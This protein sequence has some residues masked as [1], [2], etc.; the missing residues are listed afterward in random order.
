MALPPN[1]KDRAKLF[2]DED[3]A[4]EW[5]E[6]ERWPEGPVCP[7]CGVVDRA[8]KLTPKE[9]SSRPVRKGVWKCR[10]CRK[11]FTVTIGTIFAETHIPLNKW[12]YAIH[13]MCSSKK[14]ISANQLSRDLEITYKSA[15][16][17]AHRI[18]KAMEK[19]PMQE[20]LTG[21]I[22]A[23]ETFVGGKRRGM[24]G[25]PTAKGTKTIVFTLVQRD[26]EARSYVVPDVKRQTLRT[27][28][29]RNVE[30]TASIMTDE[31]A[32]YVGLNK[33]FA[34]HE[35]VNHSADEYVRGI[36]HV[37]FAESFFSLLKRGIIGTFHHVSAKHLQ[38]YME[39]FD[40]RWNSRKDK[41]AERMKL[42]IAGTE[43]VRL[44]YKA[45]PG[46]LP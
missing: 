9:G 29:R 45:V 28:I 46:L 25:G 40:F 24:S 18:R 33:E 36:V 17:L 3:A 42:C 41:D 7:Q 31:M 16:F 35:S 1:F 39:E 27:I 32:S 20:K 37:N 6:A 13:L 34:S 23:D 26:G 14:G 8:Y 2:A 22:E 43:G 44:Y 11:Q 4:R 38:R 12:L 30:G 21:T 15:W 19:E 10:D 5:L